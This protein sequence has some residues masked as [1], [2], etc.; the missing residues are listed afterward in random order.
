MLKIVTLLLLLTALHFHI[1]AQIPNYPQI[2]TVGTAKTIGKGK[3]DVSILRPSRYGIGKKSE[4]S[5]HPIAFFVLPHI[6]YKKNWLDANIK[7]ATVHGFHY[8][9]IVLKQ[10]QKH[11]IQNYIPLTDT[12][13][14]IFAF[15]NEILFS[16]VL[17][18]KTSCTPPNYV[19]TLKLGNKFAIKGEGSE[20]PF[21]DEKYFYQETSTY[22]KNLLWYI[23]M[24]LDGHL[25]DFFDFTVDLDFQTINFI[26][27]WA[28]THKTLLRTPLG[29]RSF[30]LFG[31]WASFG[32]YPSGNRFGI[33]PLLDF[34][35]EFSRKHSKSKELNLF[36]DK[37]F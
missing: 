14:H 28:I 35:W 32:T 5:L 23:G 27:D 1:F 21:F 36:E 17:K 24:D 25:T 6:D 37:M 19:L 12:V 13:P 4:I 30:I 18:K 15:K 29:K 2:W 20:P 7:I 34:S 31:Y 26:D 10:I 8:P 16:T 22:R 3:F 11:E 9:K 33:V